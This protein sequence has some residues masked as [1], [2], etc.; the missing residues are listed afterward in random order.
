MYVRKKRCPLH[1][2]MLSFSKCTIFISHFKYKYADIS[3][4]YQDL[5]FLTLK[6]CRSQKFAVSLQHQ[7]KKEMYKTIEIEMYRDLRD[8]VEEIAYFTA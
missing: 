8:W 5:V 3:K 4:S 2:S 7:N 6:I 1:P